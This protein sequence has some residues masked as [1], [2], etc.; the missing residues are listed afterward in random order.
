MVWRCRE[1][2]FSNIFGFYNL[3]DQMFFEFYFLGHFSILRHRTLCQEG[4]HIKKTK[5]IWS[6]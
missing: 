4:K 3:F 2:F 5:N 6:N 1:L